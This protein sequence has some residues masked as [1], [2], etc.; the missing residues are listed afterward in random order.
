MIINDTPNLGIECPQCGATLRVDR[1]R[2]FCVRGIFF[3]MLVACVFGLMALRRSDHPDAIWILW[4]LCMG[5]ALIGAL[6]V[7]LTRWRLLR[8]RT[9]AAGEPVTLP[10][11]TPKAD[12]DAQPGWVCRFCHEKNPLNFASC[13]KCQHAREAPA[14][15]ASG[16]EPEAHR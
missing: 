16:K 8:L 12:E 7:Q 10:L 11:G 5:T 2:Y 15:P 9:V 3:A 13:W 4:A 1:G 6:V 14:P